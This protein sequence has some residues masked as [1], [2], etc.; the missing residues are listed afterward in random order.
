MPLYPKPLVIYYTQP[1]DGGDSLSDDSLSKIGACSSNSGKST[2]IGNNS[3][4]VWRVYT[5]AKAGNVPPPVHSIMV[6][7]V[8]TE[9]AQNALN[10]V[11]V[12]PGALLM[13]PNS[14]VQ[15]PT[16]PEY[17]HWYA[18]PALTAVYAQIVD[19]EEKAIDAAIDKS[20][21]VLREGTRARAHLTCAKIGYDFATGAIKTYQAESWK[22][23]TEE[24]A[25]AVES[26]AS[27]N[28]ECR[29]ALEAADTEQLNTR[30]ISRRVLPALDETPQTERLLKIA[31]PVGRSFPFADDVLRICAKIS[32]GC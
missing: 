4:I 23:Q 31:G 9:L 17:V 12:P 16:W 29:D 6:P 11:V 2:F 20:P 7:D 18:D 8:L 21:E 3:D 30:A 27:T 24:I 19:L 15:V 32:K 5:D 13:E 25:K 28:K 10:G 14:G 22:T 1:H 26:V